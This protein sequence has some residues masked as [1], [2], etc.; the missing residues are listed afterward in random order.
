MSH[1]IRAL[2]LLCFYAATF[3]PELGA[4]MHRPPGL[5]PGVLTL[6]LDDSAEEKTTPVDP[7]PAPP[8]DPGDPSTITGRV[9]DGYVRGAKVYLDIND[10]GMADPGEPSSVSGVGGRYELTLTDNQVACADNSTLVAEVPVGA[11]D[12]E[13][14]VVEDAYTMASPPGRE[15]RLNGHSEVNIT[16]LTSI[17]WAELRLLAQSGDLP[18]LSC[19]ELRN[20]PEA[21]ANYEE[22]INRVIGDA[23]YAYNVPADQLFSDYVAADDGATRRTAADIVIGLK[24][25]LKETLALQSQYPGATVSVVVSKAFG[26]DAKD[27]I[28]S[29]DSLNWYRL[30]VVFADEITIRE[31]ARLGDDVSTVLYLLGRSEKLAALTNSSGVAYTSD[32]EIRYTGFEPASYWCQK[33]ENITVHEE[34]DGVAIQFEVVNLSSSQDP[35]S[36]LDECKTTGQT[37]DG[38]YVFIDASY[39]ATKDGFSGEGVQYSFYASP[40]P[41]LT[42]VHDLALN[43]EIVTREQIL[44]TLKELEWHF[45]QGVDARASYT[46]KKLFFPGGWILK[47]SSGAD[48]SRWE[49]YEEFEDGTRSEQCAHASFDADYRCIDWQGACPDVTVENLIPGC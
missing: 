7:A 8:T 41:Y 21:L 15:A 23:V 26:E 29:P 25:S 20:N 1:T 32:Y 12:E 38:R 39:T 22:L 43:P 6:L 49:R 13:R 4:D 33:F 14:G 28:A 45:E 17:L 36:G 5:N 35:V 34:A 31:A 9:I 10:N 30:T 11:V 42:N 44:T 3:A 27:P 19:E 46:T 2:L 47:V 16:P 37:W 48:L 40:Y 18:G 24:N